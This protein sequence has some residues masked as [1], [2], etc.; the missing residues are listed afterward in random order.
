MCL[1]VCLCVSLSFAYTFCHEACMCPS[2][3]F[4]LFS[5]GFAYTF[6]HEACV[7][8]MF[9]RDVSNRFFLAACTYAKTQGPQ[10][11]AGG[12]YAGR[13]PT[14]PYPYFFPLCSPH[15][16]ARPAFPSSAAGHSLL[17]DLRGR[18]LSSARAGHFSSARAGHCSSARA[19]Q[20]LDG[21]E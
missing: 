18:F 20:G 5:W 11:Q 2:V 10:A 17:L 14:T 13:A 6:C 3:C 8:H 7:A 4:G 21:S 15:R 16:T 1:S 9:C 12:C 19:G